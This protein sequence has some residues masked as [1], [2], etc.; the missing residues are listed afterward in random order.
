MT[1]LRVFLV[2]VVVCGVGVVGEEVCSV[3]Q[4]VRGEGLSE[5]EHSDLQQKTVLVVV[6]VLIALT[7]VFEL[8]KD[9]LE[10]LAEG[11]MEPLMDSMWKELTVLGFIGLVSFIA[12][13]SGALSGL[14]CSLYGESET[15][16]EDVESVHMLLFLVMV[17]FLVQVVLLVL[18]G[19]RVQSNWDALEAESRNPLSILD[20]MFPS[21]SAETSRPAPPGRSSSPSSS[22][23]SPL[24]APVSSAED[25]LDEDEPRC[26]L[27]LL[28]LRKTGRREA[29]EY[30]LLRELFVRPWDAPADLPE[31][32]DFARYLI[33]CLGEELGEIVDVHWATWLFL[34]VIFVGMYFAFQ[35]SA[36][37]KIAVFAAF[38]YTI[39]ASLLLVSSKLT[40]IR[41]ALL[42]DPAEVDAELLAAVLTRTGTEELLKSPLRV[43]S[44]LTRRPQMGKQLLCPKYLA[45]EMAASESG[46]GIARHTKLSA[47]LVR[48]TLGRVSNPHEYLFW[49]G[50]AGPRL[51]FGVIQMALLLVSIYVAVFSFFISRLILGLDIHGIYQAILFLVC[52]VPMLV[53]VCEQLPYIITKHIEVCNVEML[54]DKQLMADVERYMKTRK[55][56]HALRLLNMANFCSSYNTLRMVAPGSD[57]AGMVSPRT[58][59]TPF[60]SVT[61]VGE[62]SGEATLMAT[63]AARLPRSPSVAGSINSTPTPTPAPG[64]IPSPRGFQSLS[65]D[66]P[67]EEGGGNGDGNG[68]GNGLINENDPRIIRIRSLFEEF[69]EDGSGTIGLDELAPVLRA[70]GFSGLD[71]DL[72][73]FMGKAVDVD[74]SGELEFEEFVILI[75]GYERMQSMTADESISALFALFD[76]DNSG[77]IS[78]EEFSAVLTSLSCLF[79]Q[80]DVRDLLAEVDRDGDGQIDLEEFTLWVRDHMA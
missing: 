18:L 37:A 15:V 69:D 45:D 51:L 34:E 56:L 38:G 64:T 39:V 79:S 63:A 68:D 17:L 59:H 22:R 13:K 77:E 40:S 32:F 3:G 78:A 5:A 53:V 44:T 49:F 36:P 1:T 28:N 65:L 19:K 12:S 57:M 4:E 48:R 43:G 71:D 35:L 74:G 67:P 33:L 80:E 2:V 73:D 46:T 21:F 61:Q 16:A 72:V 14:S 24:L 62:L 75:S 25:E 50:A 70:L 76:S 11:P 9:K 54:K 27:T 55:S 10:E 6:S 47:R 20:R 7:I 26:S 23:H 60:G 58:P 42:P 8:V 30:L 29:Y 52:A 31:D 66:I 41:K